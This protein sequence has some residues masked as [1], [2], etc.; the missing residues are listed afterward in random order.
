MQRGFPLLSAFRLSPAR[1]LVACLGAATLATAL[2]VDAEALVANCDDGSVVFAQ[3]WEDVH[4]AGAA[5]VAAGEAPRL[6]LASASIAP[7]WRETRRRREAARE[8]DLE[9]QVER[10]RAALRTARPHERTHEPQGFELAE[11]EHRALSR[12]IE[13]S[14]QRAALD[15]AR[16]DVNGSGARMQVAHSAAFQ[17]QLFES[18]EASGREGSGR[19]LVFS[20]APGAASLDE[21]PAFAQ[22]GATFRPRRADPGQLG[23]IVPQGAAPGAQRRQLGYVVLPLGFDLARPLVLFWGEAVSAA[24]L[25][26]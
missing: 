25:D 13:L 11:A 22:R 24:R 17:S 3:R 5:E 12:F 7:D 6:G 23:W 9:A 4:C 20:L 21:V 2:C 14:Q 16:S 8:L 19:V 26:P 1:R 15:V 18:L 10:A